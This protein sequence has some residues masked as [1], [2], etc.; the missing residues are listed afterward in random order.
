ME[1]DERKYKKLI[2]EIIAAFKKLDTE[3]LAH[4]MVF[5]ALIKPHYSDAEHSLE[6]AINNPRIQKIM[7][8][9]YDLCISQESSFADLDSGTS[10]RTRSAGVLPWSAR[11][12]RSSLYSV[13]HRF[14]FRARSFLCRKCFPR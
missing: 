4:K 1:I 14:S 8:E 3:L 11:C 5:E 13:S 7:R 9:K 2:I 12:G 10:S 6:S